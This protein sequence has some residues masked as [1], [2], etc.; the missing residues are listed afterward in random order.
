MGA[1][2]DREMLEVAKEECGRLE[3]ELKDTQTLFALAVMNTGGVLKI[4]DQA[5]AAG[6]R[7][8]LHAVR[9]L[10]HRFTRFWVSYPSTEQAAPSLAREPDNVAKLTRDLED[11]YK[12]IRAFVGEPEP[13]PDS[14]KKQKGEEAAPRPGDA[15]STHAGEGE[16]LCD[17][18][19]RPCVWLSLGHWAHLPDGDW[20]EPRHEA[21]VTRWR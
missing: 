4:T 10:A 6:D 9:D 19:R 14:R 2:D 15:Q 3:K 17:V 5:L 20:Q 12:T 13:T 21:K 7:L 8:E 1:N 18:C 11:A 16:R